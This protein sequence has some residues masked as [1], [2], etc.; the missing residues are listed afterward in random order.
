[1]C[2]RRTRQ[3]G[4][5]CRHAA[6]VHRE[7]RVFRVFRGLVLCEHA[8]LMSALLS[9]RAMPHAVVSEQ[10]RVPAHGSAVSVMLGAECSHAIM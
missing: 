7:C 6:C 2:F 1:M 3:S 10:D 4:T 9:A 5:A 8:A